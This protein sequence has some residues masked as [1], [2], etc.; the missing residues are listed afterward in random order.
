MFWGQKIEGLASDEMTRVQEARLR[1]IVKYSYEKIALYKGKL[2]EKGIHPEEIRAI[3]VYFTSSFYH[4]VRS[5][6]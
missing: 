3:D 1:R 6:G 4:K 5:Q 2:D